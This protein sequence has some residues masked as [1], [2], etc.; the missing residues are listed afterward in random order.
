M[1]SDNDTTDAIAA[2]AA[3]R[4]A[5]ADA[6]KAA[7]AATAEARAATAKAETATRRLAEYENVEQS[8]LHAQGVAVPNIKTMIPLV[9]EQTSTFYSRW[10]T[11]FLNTVA[12][13]ALDCLVLS[14]DDFSTDPHWHHMDCTVKS[15]LYGTVSP[16]LIEA[17]S[18]AS[19]TSR[20]I[21]LGL[22]DQFIGNKETRAILLDAEFRT[23]VQGDLSITDYCNKMKRMADALG[24]L[25]EPVLDRTL[26]L[27]VLRGLN[28]RY[29]HMAALIKRT[30]PFPSYSDVRADLLIEEMT[31][32]NKSSTPTALV[33]TTPAHPPGPRPGV[34]SSGASGSTNT[35]GHG[36]V[37]NGNQGGSGN[38]GGSN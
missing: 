25:G 8:Q 27:N 28:E 7:E 34:P 3:L 22:E 4:Q 31:L 2:D 23:L 32:A 16:D 33:A 37:N 1:P 5:I 19:P 13:Y 21:W 6:T 36:N 38:G 12:K 18:T 9:L 24:T 17:V 29:S 35:N 15:W 10:R 14:D 30:R 26:V 11:I 20:S